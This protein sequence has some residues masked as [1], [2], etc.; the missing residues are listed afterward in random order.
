[1]GE[2]SASI[3]ADQIMLTEDVCVLFYG[4]LELCPDYMTTTMLSLLGNNTTQIDL[5]TGA[6]KEVG[7]NAAVGFWVKLIF[8]R[9]PSLTCSILLTDFL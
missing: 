3:Y 4:L 8:L 5:I 1:M 9:F 2:R 6:H 7:S